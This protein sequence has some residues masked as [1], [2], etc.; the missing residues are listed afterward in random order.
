MRARNVAHHAKPTNQRPARVR[1]FRIALVGI[2]LALALV[3]VLSLTAQAA[4]ERAL[5]P[6]QST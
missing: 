2:A 5:T 4:T 3:G 1:W 6:I